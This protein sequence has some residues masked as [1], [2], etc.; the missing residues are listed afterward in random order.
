MRNY[1]E[2]YIE[3]NQQIAEIHKMGKY[4][5]VKNPK[6]IEKLIQ[7]CNKNGQKIHKN[8]IVQENVFRIIR[9]YDEYI[10]RRKM[11]KNLNVFGNILDNM[12]ISKKKKAIGKRILAGSLATV[13]TLSGAHALNQTKEKEKEL[14]YQ[15]ELV[16]PDESITDSIDEIELNNNSKVEIETE[17]EELQEMLKKDV[18]HFTYEDRTHE[19]NVKNARRYEDIFEKYA[20]R[21]GID[22]NLLI[23]MAAQESGGDHYG[24]IGKGPA[25]GI[26]QVEK[27][28]HIGSKVR[29]YNFETHKTDEI[30]VTEE[31]LQ[32]LE[33][34]IQIGTMILRTCIE[35]N[36]YNIPLALQTYNFGPGNMNS[37]LSMCSD[38]EH[39]E[40]TEL[41]TS[42]EKS[43]W[44]QYRSFLNIGD[45]QY[46]EHV[47]SFLANNT[48]LTMKKQDNSPISIQ[49]VNDYQKT[50]TSL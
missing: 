8:T 41:R 27:S 45:P 10:K 25:A 48:V 38:L 4:K 50:K 30:L 31:N 42:P 1:I 13:I 9:E 26:M 37:V 36:H 24:H 2:F 23:A 28:V 46:V 3:D 34:N 35:D 49:I 21:Y 43:D 7:I 14:S 17:T 33:T 12:K 11:I 6:N 19:E 22:K 44:L 39:I 32:D 20:K 5:I 18:F 29:A 47:L 16:V 15:Q 40:E